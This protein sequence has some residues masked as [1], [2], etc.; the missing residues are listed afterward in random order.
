LKGFALLPKIGLLVKLKTGGV[1]GLLA[2][3]GLLANVAAK[4]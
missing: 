4:F 2:K 3:K 1:T